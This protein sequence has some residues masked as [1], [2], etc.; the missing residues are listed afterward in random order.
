[1]SKIPLL[2]DQNATT[3]IQTKL[4]LLSI[5]LLSVGTWQKGSASKYKDH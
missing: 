4:K 5:C 3:L 1:M 2:I